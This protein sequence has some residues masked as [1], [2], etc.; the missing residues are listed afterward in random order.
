MRL[1][2]LI[3]KCEARGVTKMVEY[4]VVDFLRMHR[5]DFIAQFSLHEDFPSNPNRN[6]NF[7]N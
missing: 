2:E 5:S 6:N 1:K 7:R 4:A 3:S